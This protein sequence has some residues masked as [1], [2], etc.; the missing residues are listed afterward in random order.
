MVSF[1]LLRGLSAGRQSEQV[2]SNDRP[3]PPYC[4]IRTPCCRV[5]TAHG[6]R[7]VGQAA[8]R[9]ERPVQGFTHEIEDLS[10]EVIGQILPVAGRDHA[11]ADSA[12]RRPAEEDRN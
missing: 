3:T 10:P 8:T 2:P 5:E 6:R 11:K 4:V 9:E 7:I 12:E 1:A